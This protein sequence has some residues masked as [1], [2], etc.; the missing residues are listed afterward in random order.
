VLVTH[1]PYP[2]GTLSS[3]GWD[4]IFCWTL[5]SAGSALTSHLLLAQLLPLRLSSQPS[6]LGLSYCLSGSA[7]ASRAQLSP[8]GL[9]YRLS[10]SAIASRAQLSPL[11]RCYRL[12]G[13][14]IASRALLSPLGR[15]YHLSGAAITSRAQ[16]RLSPLGR[17]YGYRRSGA[18]TAIASRAQLRLSPLG[19]S[20]GYRLSGAA[21]AIASRARFA[22]RPPP[23]RARNAERLP[24]SSAST[25]R[26]H[27]L[28]PR[29][30]SS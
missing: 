3:A 25:S 21:T 8:L 18:A 9:S 4:F 15:C 17:S 14:A 11:G 12:S 2:T 19:R 29:G 1:P 30:L 22:P 26:A 28:A 6:P 20:Y 5:S 13:A 23:C 16:L 24:G 7:I 10:G 27:Q